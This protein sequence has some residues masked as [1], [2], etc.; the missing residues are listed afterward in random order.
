MI[1]YESPITI[2]TVDDSDVVYK[3]LGSLLNENKHI[4]WIGHA[5]SLP[6]AYIQITE[7]KPQIVILDIQLKERSSLEL[8]EYLTKK[9]P[10]IVVIMLT[11][12][13]IAPYRK[14][15]TELGAK[16]FLDKSSEFEKISQIVEELLNP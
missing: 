5:F 15:C 12:L 2:F 1:L 16:Y 3:N 13:A 10:D 4:S 7:Q 11:N 8:L 14:K 9:Y 6:E